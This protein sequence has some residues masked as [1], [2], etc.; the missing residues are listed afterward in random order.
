MKKYSTNDPTIA[1]WY[2]ENELERIRAIEF[3]AKDL[4]SEI[5]RNSKEVKN[6]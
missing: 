5:N 6:D 3:S 1:I 4:L 2:D